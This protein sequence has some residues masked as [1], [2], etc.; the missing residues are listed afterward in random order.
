MVSQGGNPRNPEIQKM[1]QEA[2]MDGK[3]IE[4]IKQTRIHINHLNWK[5]DGEIDWEEFLDL[6]KKRM[7][8]GKTQSAETAKFVERKEDKPRKVK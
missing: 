2:D 4:I 6:T 7:K 5:G 1:F 8:M 3:E